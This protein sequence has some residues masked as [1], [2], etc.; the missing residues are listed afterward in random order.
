M[1]SLPFRRLLFALRILTSLQ[2]AARRN[3]QLQELLSLPPAQV[4]AGQLHLNG[5]H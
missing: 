3:C 2:T 4:C 1:P 5:I